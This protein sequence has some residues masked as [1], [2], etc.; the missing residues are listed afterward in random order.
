[1]K[2]FSLVLALVAGAVGAQ[3]IDLPPGP[4]VRNCDSPYCLYQQPGAVAKLL[5]PAV[6]TVTV[7]V[8]PITPERVAVPGQK[9]GQPTYVRVCGPYGCQ[10]MQEPAAIVSVPVAP[11]PPKVY[12][13]QP[14]PVNVPTVITWGTWQGSG[15]W[16]LPSGPPLRRHK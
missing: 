3:S 11:P 14:P 5:P 10:L 12:W 6:Q 16:G 4:D 15:P 7:V 13:Y 1:M 8:T 9:A 2:L